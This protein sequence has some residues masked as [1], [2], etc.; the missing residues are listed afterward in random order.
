MRAKKNMQTRAK[1]NSE[2]QKESQSKIIRL[3]K[4]QGTAGRADQYLECGL[5][6]LFH[7]KNEI[8]SHISNQ[9]FQ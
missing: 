8:T 5:E 1:Q 7:C 9:R 4:K 6:R 3:E 2:A